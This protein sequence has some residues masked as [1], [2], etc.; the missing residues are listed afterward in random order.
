MKPL[1]IIVAAAAWFAAAPVLA[2][3]AKGPNGGRIVDAGSY[4][5]ELVVKAG[6]VDVFLTDGSDKPVTATGFKG[7]AILMAG[8]KAQRIPLEVSDKAKLAGKSPV[9]LP[10]DVKGVVQLT[11]PDGK[12]V[13]GQY[14]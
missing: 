14:K 2:H 3:E 7:T 12:T 1:T 11:T 13:Q 8:G 4:H 9:S 5:V 6:Q 10:A